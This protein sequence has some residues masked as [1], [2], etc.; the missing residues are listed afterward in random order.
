MLRG[1]FFLRKNTVCPLTAGENRAIILSNLIQTVEAEITAAMPPQR[2]RGAES[3]ARN[4]LSNGPRR[5]QSNA[6]D[7]R[8]FCN[9]RPA[10]VAGDMSVS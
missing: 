10:L 1:R 3:R 5:V 9:A 6:S 7:R 2:A 8:V 4:T